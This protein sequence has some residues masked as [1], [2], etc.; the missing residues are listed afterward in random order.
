MLLSRLSFVQR[1][2]ICTWPA[3]PRSSP[4]QQRHRVGDHPGP[5][6]RGVRVIGAAK[7]A[8]AN[9]AKSLSKEAAC[10]GIR[11]TTVSP[12]AGE[13][14]A[15]ARYRRRRRHRRPSGRRRTR[16]HRP[17]AASESATGRF[18]QPEEVADLVLLLASDR[19]G[20]VTGADFVID[21]G[22]IT[23]L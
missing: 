17:K 20:N 5:G 19:T 11:L 2:W 12:R 3:R 18:T 16:G 7:A 1:R 6:R 13:H 10:R 14:R 8:L 23:T 15:V 22:L 9:F 4:G 21:G